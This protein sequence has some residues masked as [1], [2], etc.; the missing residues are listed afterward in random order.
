MVLEENLMV[1]GFFCLLSLDE[2]G[3]VFTA[4]LVLSASKDKN[5]VWKAYYL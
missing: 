4:P 2:V 1:R 5:G 3:R